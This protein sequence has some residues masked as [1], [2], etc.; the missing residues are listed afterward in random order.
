MNDISE[1]DDPLD[2][3][4]HR[5]FAEEHRKLAPEPFVAETRR[6]VRHERKRLQIL[7]RGA[8]VVAIA[9]IIVASPLLIAASSRVSALLD[10]SFVLISDWLGTPLGAFAALIVGAIVVFGYRR[11]RWR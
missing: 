9:V 6:R 8:F 10:T 1:Q 4:L 3:A 7:K 5:L 11:R 2:P